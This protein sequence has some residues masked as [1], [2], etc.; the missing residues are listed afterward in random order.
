MSSAESC[1]EHATQGPAE[2][3]G[4]TSVTTA[5]VRAS[6]ADLVRAA[7]QPRM[8]VVLVVVLAAALGCGALGRWQLD[9][10]QERGAQAE[11]HRIDELAAAGPVPI[12]QV[13]A[14]QV[15]MSGQLVGK[16]V[17]VTGTFED[18]Q[19]LVEGRAHAGRTGYLVLSP[20]RV[21][22]DG[23]GGATWADL[24]GAPVIPVVRGWVASPEDAVDAAPGTVTVTG[25]LQTSESVGEGMVGEG[26]TD[27]ISSGHLAN[28][29]GGPVYSGYLVQASSDPAD[30]GAASL[31][32][33]ERPRLVG[34]DGGLNLQNLFY[35]VQWWIFGLFAVGLWL[36]AVRDEA[37]AE[38]DDDAFTGWEDLQP[39][40]ERA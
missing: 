36:Q 21:S 26:I 38:R 19:L 12:G 4:E 31:A 11:Q 23:T 8:L 1:G 13:L 22:D 35:A 18:G 27:S 20:L 6:A 15:S 17:S 3:G 2:D 39:R 16:T 40:D 24:S 9:R 37:R 32:L 28:V 34:S 7:L 25:Y 30:P 14:P 5:P 29:W 33:L 10:A